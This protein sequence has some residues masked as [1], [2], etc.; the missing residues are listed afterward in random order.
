[1]LERAHDIEAFFFMTRVMDVKSSE[2]SLYHHYHPCYLVLSWQELILIYV[3]QWR[4]LK[5]V[6]ISV[7]PISPP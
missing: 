6:C 1:M 4:I 3:H 5:V 2:S 7:C